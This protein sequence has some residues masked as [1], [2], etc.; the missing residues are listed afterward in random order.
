MKYFSWKWVAFGLVYAMVVMSILNIGL[1]AEIDG[2]PVPEFVRTAYTILIY[3]W[4]NFTIITAISVLGFA[5]FPWAKNDNEA[6]LMRVIPM[7]IT[8]AAVP[9]ATLA[10]VLAF[11]LAS[12]LASVLGVMLGIMLG[13]VLAFVLIPV[14]KAVLGTLPHTTKNIIRNAKCIRITFVKND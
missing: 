12:V 5:T 10:F 13:V 7:V 14:L 4:G 11:V 2:K 8:M 6:N 3:G 1:P 9:M